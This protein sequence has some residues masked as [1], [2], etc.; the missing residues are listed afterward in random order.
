MLAGNFRS[1]LSVTS[2]GR[3]YAL[4]SQVCGRV[5]LRFSSWVFFC[6]LK[7]VFDLGACVA[8]LSF[9][10]VSVCPRNSSSVCIFHLLRLPIG[11]FIAL[12]LVLSLCSSFFRV[13][14]FL[15]P[16]LAFLQNGSKINCS[17]I[18]FFFW[19]QAKQIAAL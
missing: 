19:V 9:P 17:G 11:G 14:N 8:V 15:S 5:L 2:S 12:E 18:F 13:Q 1:L 6:S 7:G 10:Q 16:V 3:H 4:F